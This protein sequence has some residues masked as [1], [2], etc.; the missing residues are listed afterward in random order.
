MNI[1]I[2][3]IQLARGVYVCFQNCKFKFWIVLGFRQFFTKT[4]CKQT[5]THLQLGRHTHTPQL[6]L[7]LLHNNSPRELRCA[8]QNADRDRSLFLHI[9][10]DGQSTDNNHSF[11]V[12]AMQPTKRRNEPF[13][14]QL[15]MEMRVYLW[16]R[17]TRRWARR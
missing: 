2:D 16:S 12:F 6:F 13:I 14:R 5:K 9:S 10:N 15:W 17:E 1:D 7:L 4:P 3:R 11:V 8:L